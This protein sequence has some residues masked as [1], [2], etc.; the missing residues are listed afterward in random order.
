MKTSTRSHINQHIKDE[1]NQIF[2]GRLK[3]NR[4]TIMEKFLQKVLKMLN[5]LKSK[6]NL[7][8]LEMSRVSCS[9]MLEELQSLLIKMTQKQ[10]KLFMQCV[11]IILLPTAQS[12][13]ANGMF[14]IK[15]RTFKKKSKSTK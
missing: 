14:Q 15:R 2:L 6:R 1:I 7:K 11:L 13:V 8:N 10:L 3:L 12:S 4:T 5:H 9:T